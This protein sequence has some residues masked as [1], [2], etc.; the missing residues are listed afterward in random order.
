M[1]LQGTMVAAFAFVN[2]VKLPLYVGIGLIGGDTLL[3]ALAL[4]PAAY[5]GIRL[6]VWLHGR[7]RQAAFDR[8]LEIGLAL[9]GARLV[10]DGAAGLL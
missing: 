4:A 7:V 10:W 2:A 1:L 9:A 3:T 6:G 8:I 5:A